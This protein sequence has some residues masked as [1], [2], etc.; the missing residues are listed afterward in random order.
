MNCAIRPSQKINNKL[1]RRI[2]YATTQKIIVP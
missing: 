2:D 1:R